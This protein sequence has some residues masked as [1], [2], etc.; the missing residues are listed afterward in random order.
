MGKKG[1]ARDGLL[2]PELER[3]DKELWGGADMKKIT[4]FFH[5]ENSGMEK[6]ALDIVAEYKKYTYFNQS[7][8]IIQ[9]ILRNEEYVKSLCPYE[10][11]K[12]LKQNVD[13]EK[14]D[15]A[16]IPDFVKAYEADDKVN[17]FGK[18]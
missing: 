17:I 7:Q 3:G 10:K 1:E 6:K 11:A 15:V 16:K 12:E 9:L 18:D 8:A 4:V 2:F 14:D 5:P 13:D